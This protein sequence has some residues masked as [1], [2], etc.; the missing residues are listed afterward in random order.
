MVVN[1]KV[2]RFVVVVGVVAKV[3]VVREK[4]VAVCCWG[5]GKIAEEKNYSPSLL[6]GV[7]KSS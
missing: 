2:M 5:V 6:T 1:A 7:S 3:K 4:L